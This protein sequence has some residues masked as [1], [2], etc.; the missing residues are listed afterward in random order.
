M[1]YSL[2]GD[3]AINASRIALGVMRIADKTREEAASIVGT[4]LDHGINF[5]DT[6]DIY[7]AGKSSA[8]LGCAFHD[9]GINRED[10]VVQTKVGVVCGQ[11]YDFSRQ[12]IVESLE[13]EL[14]RLRTE[15]VDLLVLH[16]P[17]VLVDLDELA[18]TFTALQQ[19]GKV[20]CFGVSNMSP[21]QVDL[22]QSVLAQKLEVN[23]LQFGL[24]HAGMVR[25]E[26]HVNVGEPSE[27]GDDDGLL[28]YSRLHHMTIQAWSPFQCPQLGA[29]FIDH[30][31]LA[32][33]NDVLRRIASEHG[34]SSSAVAAAWILRHPAGIQVMVGTMNPIHLGDITAA[35]DI[36]LDRQ[37]WYDLYCAAGNDLP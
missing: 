29:S 13:Q 34:V 26:I 15:Y 21:G 35:A 11:R 14:T 19:Q 5:F 28:S 18:E 30:P 27:S 4:A 1:K 10:V 16:R 17:D 9:L 8:V 23:Q 6:A 2:L 36:T 24:C 7:G 37:E 20:R 12:H 25:H 32:K 22:L 3:S 31:Q 33:L